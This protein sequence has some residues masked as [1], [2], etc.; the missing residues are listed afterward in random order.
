MTSKNAAVLALRSAQ[1]F[2]SS[3][4]TGELAGDPGFL[5]MD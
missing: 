5:V 1:Y 2:N 4:S 3:R